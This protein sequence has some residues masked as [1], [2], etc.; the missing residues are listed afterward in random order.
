MNNL[1]GKVVTAMITDKNEKF[2]FAQKEGVTI[3]VI[4]KDS[5]DYEIGE[6]IEGFVYID[7]KEDVVMMTELPEIREEKYGWGE[8]VAVQHDLGVFVDVGWTG[9]DLAVSM[10]ELPIFKNLWPRKGDQLYLKPIVDEKNRLWGKLADV[11]QIL[12]EA[13]KGDEA[14]HNNDV[15]GT[16][17]SALKAGSYVWLED[18]YLGFIHPNE[19]EEEPRLGKSVDGRVIGLR[20]DNV[21]YISLLPRVHEV[22]DEDAA[23]ILEVLKRSEDYRIPYH[24]KSNPD[25]IREYFGI[26]KGQFKRAVGRLMKNNLVKQDENGTSMTKEAIEKEQ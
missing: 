22:L 6:M 20:D 11:S 3:K 9:K 10:D 24:D 5:D 14:M 21:L 4:D 8:V 25:D 1:L 17:V 18:D 16:I 26:S 12:E 23:M 19:R 13:K 2:L 15:K 7:Q